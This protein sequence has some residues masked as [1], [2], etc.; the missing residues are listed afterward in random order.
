MSMHSEKKR[1][2]K[3]TAIHSLLLLWEAQEKNVTSSHLL[4]KR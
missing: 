3:M 4:V 2:N 1:D